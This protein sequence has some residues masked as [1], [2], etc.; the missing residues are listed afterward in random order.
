MKV[1]VTGC[2]GYIG[3][4]LVKF[5]ISKEYEVDIWDWEFNP[6]QL[7]DIDESYD[8]VFHLGAIS[9]TTEKDVEKI[10]TQN[11]EYSYRLLMLCNEKKVNL[12][13]ASSAS[14]YGDAEWNTDLGYSEECAPAPKSPYAW[15]K[16]LFDRLVLKSIPH[17]D[18]KVYGFRYFNVWG[19]NIVDDLGSG[20][21]E[22]DKGEQASLWYK[23]RHTQGPHDLFKESNDIYRDFVHVEDVCAVHWIISHLNELPE[24]GIYNLGSGKK[25]SIGNIASAHLIGNPH[26]DNVFNEVEMPEELKGQYQYNTQ[27]NIVKLMNV[28]GMY[29]FTDIEKALMNTEFAKP[30]Q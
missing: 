23:W 25:L 12:Q 3:S 5:L 22:S 13:Y 27:A 17:L 29:T 18:I 1:M 21:D 4:N 7:P 26:L 8:W 16:Y 10:M 6:E 28:L 30:K 19:D 2:G 14:V 11:Y 20:K 15:S 9:S 24:S